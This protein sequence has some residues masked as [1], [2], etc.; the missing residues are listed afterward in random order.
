[1]GSEMEKRVKVVVK[2][3]CERVNES[4]KRLVREGDDEPEKRGRPF[5]SLK[6]NEFTFSDWYSYS[7]LNEL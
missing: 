1:M 5:P 6:M 3:R 2:M 7:H 4:E